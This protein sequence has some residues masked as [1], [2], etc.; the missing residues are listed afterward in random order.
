[1]GREQS[2]RVYYGAVFEV[3]TKIPIKGKCCFKEHPMKAT[4]M[5]FLCLSFLP[6]MA[7]A[8]KNPP[9]TDHKALFAKH[10]QI[11]KEFTLAVA[12][13]MPAEG[14]DFKPTAEE[15]SFG[16]LMVHIAAQNSDSCLLG[17]YPAT[18]SEEVIE[19]S[20]RGT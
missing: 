1:M 2:R 12:E 18:A 19:A 15:M 16:Q 17:S 20:R 11:S 10:W 9:E 5:G 3:K 6:N 14:Y 4:L 7:A 13:A 8:P